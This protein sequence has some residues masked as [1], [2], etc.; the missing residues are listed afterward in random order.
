MGTYHEDVERKMK[1][2]FGWLSE[3]DRRRYPAVEALKL[4]HAAPSTSRNSSS[5]TPR[6]SARGCTTWTS[7]RIPRLDRSEKKGGRRP[8]TEA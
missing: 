2:L 3:K 1:H 8:V 6:R 5:A 4:G 7:R